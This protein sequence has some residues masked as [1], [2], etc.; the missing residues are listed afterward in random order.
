[1]RRDELEHLIRAAGGV[2][3]ESA[4]IVVGSQSIL[5]SYSTA[6]PPEQLYVTLSGNARQ[7][8]YQR[9][10]VQRRRELTCAIAGVG[11]VLREHAGLGSYVANE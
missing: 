2:L 1:M 3:N 6:L 5:G 8:L 10:F 11:T 4:L 7:Q 9:G